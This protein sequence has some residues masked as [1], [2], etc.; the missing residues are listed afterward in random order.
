MDK[1]SMLRKKV[2]NTAVSIA[3]RETEKTGEDYSSIISKAL[4]E[5]CEKLGVERKEFIRMFI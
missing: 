5:A 2:I 3:L 1:Q 4:N